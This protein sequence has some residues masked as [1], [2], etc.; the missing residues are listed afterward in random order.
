MSLLVFEWRLMDSRKTGSF[1][2]IANNS[3]DQRRYLVC[4]YLQS[5]NTSFLDSQMKGISILSVQDS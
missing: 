2:N 3:E 4:S 5:V 1:N